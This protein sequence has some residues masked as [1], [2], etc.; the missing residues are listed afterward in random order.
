[1]QFPDHAFIGNVTDFLLM[2]FY[3]VRYVHNIVTADLSLQ[4]IR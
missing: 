3:L 1:M 4:S 2:D